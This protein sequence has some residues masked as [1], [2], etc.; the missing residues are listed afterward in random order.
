MCRSSIIRRRDSTLKLD[1]DVNSN[2]SGSDMN[3]SIGSDSSFSSPSKKVSFNN[4]LIV[5][6]IE[7]PL[8]PLKPG[9]RIV[10]D[11]VIEFDD[12]S[13]VKLG[14]QGRVC[15]DINKPIT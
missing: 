13:R 9:M 3:A 2:S 11:K 15:H 1:I 4:S 7:E 12:E 10:A 6:E 8:L 14:S 5:K